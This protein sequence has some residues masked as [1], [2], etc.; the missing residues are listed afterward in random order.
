MDKVKVS[1]CDSKEIG[2]VLN[3]QVSLETSLH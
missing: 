3:L 1:G 2:H